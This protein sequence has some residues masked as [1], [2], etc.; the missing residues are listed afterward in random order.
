[1]ANSKT[2]Y[3]A[4]MLLGTLVPWYFFGGF[5]AENGA[6]LGYFMSALFANGAAAGAVSD[7]FISA[8]IFW[9]WSFSDAKRAQVGNW[10]LVIPA[11]LAVGLSLA[12]PLYLW[13]RA[14]TEPAGAAIGSFAKTG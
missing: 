13:L 1:M 11:T 2:F 5:I 10:W 6:G 3:A 14:G 4:M 8:A 7:L 12:L 9:V